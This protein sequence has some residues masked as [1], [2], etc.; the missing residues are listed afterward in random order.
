M[1]AVDSFALKTILKEASHPL[2]DTCTHVYSGFQG[3][4]RERGILLFEKDMVYQE[5][6]L[7]NRLEI[8][9]AEE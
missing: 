5:F 8:S 1:K 4:A 6:R 2:T 9:R 7:P 3:S